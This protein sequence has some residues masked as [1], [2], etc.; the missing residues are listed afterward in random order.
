MTG[1]RNKGFSEKTIKEL[2]KLCFDEFSSYPAV[3]FVLYNIFINIEEAFEGQAMP[4]DL[5]NKFE[6]L[7]PTIEDVLLNKD[8]DSLNTLIK[9]FVQIKGA[10]HF[11]V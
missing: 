1:L 5:Y 9:S 4:K 7:I 8:I 3:Y 10:D 2:K 11:F 6:S